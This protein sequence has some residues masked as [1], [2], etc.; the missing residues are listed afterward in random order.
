MW[1]RF[2]LALI[3]LLQASPV[4][5]AQR[6]NIKT[7]EEI[8]QIK[9]PGKKLKELEKFWVGVNEEVFPVD[10]D[11]ALNAYKKLLHYFPDYSKLYGYLAFSY[12]INSVNDL[13]CLNFYIAGE[14][15]HPDINEWLEDLNCASWQN[16]WM[17]KVGMYQINDITMHTPDEFGTIKYFSRHNKIYRINV[18]EQN[19]SYMMVE[20]GKRF[21]V[22]Y[23]G[24]E[25]YLFGLALHFEDEKGT[26]F[27]KLYSSWG[28][29]WDTDDLK[30]GEWTKGK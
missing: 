1:I 3:L 27:F 13:A 7:L 8:D 4:L 15:G 26:K 9:R 12:H 5:E 11:S 24:K 16:E 10:Q 6:K 22:K 29:R 17:E 2:F 21:I 25:T 28:S 20:N 19:R 23:L 30:E 18:L 14:M